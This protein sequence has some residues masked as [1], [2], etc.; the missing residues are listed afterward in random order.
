M[1]PTKSRKL[2]ACKGLPQIEIIRN[3]WKASNPL[4]LAD[5]D[6]LVKQK[7]GVQ[8]V[9]SFLA[10]RSYRIAYSAVWHW[11]QA[12]HP[13]QFDYFAA[14]LENAKN[15]NAII[16][17]LQAGTP[18]HEGIKPE[19]LPALLR[20]YRSICVQLDD[21]KYIKDRQEFELNG[22]YLTFVE[23]EETYKDTVFELAIKESKR[24]VLAK[25]EGQ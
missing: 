6:A 22:I 17:A 7:P 4:L 21:R 14:L 23:L 16:Q 9:H 24:S 15:L 25:Y 18:T 10:E 2:K 20:E 12:K 8:C 11:Y 5:F 13:E 19:M 1:E 3:E